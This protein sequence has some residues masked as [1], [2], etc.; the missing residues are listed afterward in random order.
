MVVNVAIR[1]KVR[2]SPILRLLLKVRNSAILRLQYTFSDE[3]YGAQVTT[4][5][6]RDPMEPRYDFFIR[7]TT[8]RG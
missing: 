2:N 3:L 7:R 6:T 4:G 1:T 8:T 5:V